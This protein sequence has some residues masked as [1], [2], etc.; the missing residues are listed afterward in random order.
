MACGLLEYQRLLQ[1]SLL[2]FFIVS[3]HQL[4]MQLI[5][6]SFYLL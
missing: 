4:L 6:T 5:V 1:T 3:A 2:S